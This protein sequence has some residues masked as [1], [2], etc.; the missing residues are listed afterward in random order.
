[1]IYSFRVPL[2]DDFCEK[3]VFSIIEQWS[4]KS[5]YYSFDEIS[6]SD[7]KN[8]FSYICPEAEL[9]FINHKALNTQDNPTHIYAGRLSLSDKENIEWIADLIFQLTPSNNFVIM[10][11]YRGIYNPDQ[12]ARMERHARLTDAMNVL[13]NNNYLKDDCGLDIAADCIPLNEETFERLNNIFSDQSFPAFPM[14]F[15]NCIDEPDVELV[16]KELS[17]LLKKAVHIFYIRKTEDFSYIPDNVKEQLTHEITICFPQIH[18]FNSIPKVYDDNV[19]LCE[20]LTDRIFYYSMSN[21]SNHEITWD[22]LYALN[23]NTGNSSVSD[24]QE[25]EGHSPNAVSE[26]NAY[27][28]VN[29]YI[30]QKIKYSRKKSGLSQIELAELVN[31]TGLVIS[32]LETG[33]TTKIKSQLLRD[34]ESTLGM[35]NDELFRMEDSTDFIFNDSFSPE[36]LSKKEDPAFYPRFCRQCGK[37]LLPKSSFCSYCGAKQ[38]LD[39]E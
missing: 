34:I 16:G 7:E 20:L 13:L 5:S 35:K 14:V 31:T 39:G 37:K 27:V 1:M 24:Q 12:P 30:S 11:L 4:T 9:Q 28:L 3:D 18:V 25:E 38:I 8:Y 32:R 23:C 22:Q 6:L 19:N 29:E 36:P 33:R 10:Y 21:L 17:H 2:K 15:I 26:K